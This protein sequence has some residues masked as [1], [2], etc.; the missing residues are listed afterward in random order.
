MASTALEAARR[1][2]AFYYCSCCDC[3]EGAEERAEDL[4]AVKNGVGRY[5]FVCEIGASKYQDWDNAPTLAALLEKLH[6]EEQ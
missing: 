6:K 4:R 3:W 2:Q 5:I 1:Q